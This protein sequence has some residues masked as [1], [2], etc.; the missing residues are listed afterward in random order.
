MIDAALSRTAACRRARGLA[1]RARGMGCEASRTGLKVRILVGETCVG[2]GAGAHEAT[3]T[4]Q[5]DATSRDS[6]G[7]GVAS[8]HRPAADAIAPHF[9]RT[10][11]VSFF[12]GSSVNTRLL[13]VTPQAQ[14]EA[15]VACIEAEI[16]PMDGCAGSVTRT[17]PRS[18]AMAECGGRPLVRAGQRP[19]AGGGIGTQVGRLHESAWAATPVAPRPSHNRQTDRLSCGLFRRRLRTRLR[20]NPESRHHFPVKFAFLNFLTK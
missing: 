1:A 6:S 5:P 20:C 10:P 2:V 12:R 13:A 14:A 19:A 3:R 4:T 7:P 15:M 8:G 11:F 9:W 16:G 17:G 18:R